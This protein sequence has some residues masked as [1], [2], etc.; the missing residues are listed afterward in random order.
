MARQ[1]K[2]AEFAQSGKLAEYKK[3]MDPAVIEKHW[4]EHEAVS[5]G[6]ACVCVRVRVCVCMR[7]RVCF[8]VSTNSTQSL[9]TLATPHHAGPQL[10]QRCT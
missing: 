7:V 3:W 1:Y 4:R 8:C 10:R 5:R 6:A 2:T 9:R